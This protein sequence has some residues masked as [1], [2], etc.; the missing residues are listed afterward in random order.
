M[1]NKVVSPFSQEQI[2]SLQA[3][4]ECEMMH[5]YTCHECEKILIPSELGLSCSEHGLVQ[6]W[7]LEFTANGHWHTHEVQMLEMVEELKKDDL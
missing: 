6:T 4:Q 7:A 3:F 2:D 1:F 5:P